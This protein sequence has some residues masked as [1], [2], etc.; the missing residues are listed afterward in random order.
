M[1]L[2]ICITILLI[3]TNI[4]TSK[5]YVEINHILKTVQDNWEEM[6]E[7]RFKK[8]ENVKSDFLI[9]DNDN[10]ILLRS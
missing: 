9:I 2:S 1:Y 6:Q 5:S 8:I 4:D 7:G 3:P 10:N